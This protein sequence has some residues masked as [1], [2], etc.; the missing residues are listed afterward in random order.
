M[1]DWTT[2][3][4]D[5]IEAGKP[6]RAVDGRALRDNPVAIAEGA[7]G[8]PV[9]AAGWHPY[10]M[11]NV[12]DGA[13]GTFWDHSVDG[14]QRYVATP[15]F[16][17]GYEYMVRVEDLNRGDSGLPDIFVKGFRDL[18]GS[19]SSAATIAVSLGGVGN[20]FGTFRVVLPRVPSEYMNIAIEQGFGIPG[21]SPVSPCG[22]GSSISL[23]GTGVKIDNLEISWNSPN[24]FASGRMRLFR[25]R[26][27]ISG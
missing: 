16:E 3:P 6:G 5:V 20:L 27:Y 11:I 19:Y 26:E 2:I 4:N 12:G 1:T 14:N 8:A 23:G 24:D 13:D 22:E 18:Y 10:N 15:A 17:D 9:V 25:R 7:P 21:N